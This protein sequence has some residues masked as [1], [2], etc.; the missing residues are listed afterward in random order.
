VEQTNAATLFMV[1][2]FPF[3]PSFFINFAFGV[4]EFSRKKY[5][6][7]LYSAKLIMIGLLA[8]VG[9]SAVSAINNHW[10]ILIS[11]GILV[12]TYILSKKVTQLKIDKI[13]KKIENEEKNK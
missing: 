1:A 3:T 12:I 6:I 5:L 7:T 10:F 9:K 4:S 11:I 8:I 2:L 13:N